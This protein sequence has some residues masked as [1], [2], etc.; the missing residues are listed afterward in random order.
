[1]RV[2]ATQVPMASSPRAPAVDGQNGGQTGSQSRGDTAGKGKPLRSQAVTSA[3]DHGHA[4]GDAHGDLPDHDGGEN[5]ARF[6]AP[7]G[8]AR[9]EGDGRRDEKGGGR[10]GPPPPKAPPGK[11]AKPQRRRSGTARWHM[12]RKAVDLSLAA[13]YRMTDLEAID[14]LVQARWGSWKAVRCPH[15]GTINAHYW[16]A[17]ER[18]WKCAACG[19][20]FSVTSETVFAHRKLPPQ[21]L[22]ANT[23]LWINSAAGQP[24]LELKRHSDTSYNTVFVLQ[25]KL[26]EALI[27]GYNEGLLSGDVEMDGAHQSGRYADVKRGRPQGSR[28]FTEETPVEVLNELLASDPGRDKKKPSAYPKDRRF[29][30]TVRQRSGHRGQ[31]AVATRVAIGRA[32]DAVVAESVMGAYLAVPETTLNTDASPAY[33]VLGKSFRGHRTVEHGAMLVGPAG[34][35]NNQAE[36]LN[37]RMDRAEQGIYLN[38]EPKYMMDYGCEAAFRAD[39]RRLPNGRQLLVALNVAMTVGTSLYWTGYTHGRHRKVE[40]LHP[41]PRPAPASGPAKGRHPVKG[42]GRPPR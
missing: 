16:K 33:Q 39:T 17:R 34:E 42:S 9:G 8:P 36:E 11:G 30:I 13:V 7:V 25:H 2:V 31:G 35:N 1:M 12:S 37:W 38:I 10:R 23:L 15:C 5:G 28:G 4:G 20:S 40:L 24:A 29:F 41:G 3:D 21:K 27:R 6:R 32:E 26:R 19:R 22:I 18:R 14:F